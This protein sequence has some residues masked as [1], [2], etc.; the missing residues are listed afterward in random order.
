MLAQTIRTPLILLV[1]AATPIAGSLAQGSPQAQAP[2]KNVSQ[3]IAAVESN[4]LLPPHARATLPAGT[5]IPIFIKD[6]ITSRHNKV[7]DPVIGTIAHPVADASGGTVIPADAVFVGVISDISSE[8]DGRIV[9]TFYSVAF[10]GNTYPTQVRVISL[11]TRKQ[12][13][14]NTAGDVAKVG[15]GAVVGGIAGRLIGGNKKGTIVGVASGA[16]AGVGVTAATRKED[17]VVDAGAPVLLVL[18][19]P[20]VL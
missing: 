12:R 14:G 17:I 1:L 9:L 7:G 11:P 20:F 15:A 16:A 3:R 19:A 5:V 8:D 13:R 2:E 10:G 6:T 18:T 4:T